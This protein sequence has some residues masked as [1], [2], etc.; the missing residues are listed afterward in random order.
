M[1]THLDYRDTGEP[2]RLLHVQTLKDLAKKYGKAAVI[3]G[4]DFNATPDSGTYQEMKKSISRQLGTL[5]QRERA[6]DSQL[7][8]AQAH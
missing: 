4:G 8:T 2:E 1:S 3:I 5:R 7:Q 6:Y